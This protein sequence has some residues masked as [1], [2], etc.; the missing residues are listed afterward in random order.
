MTVDFISTGTGLTVKFQNL[1]KGLLDS[2]SYQWNFG[3]GSELSQ[4]RNPSHTYTE[5]GFFTVRLNV[6]DQDSTV[7][8]FRQYTVAVTDKA[9]THLP[10]SIYDLIDTYIPAKLF[11]CM[12]GRE[13]QL[14]IQKWQ[15]Y[16]YPLVCHCIPTG[17]YTNEL[18][19]E[20]LENQLVMQLA[21]RDFMLQQYQL[22]LGSEAAVIVENNSY[23]N[24]ELDACGCADDSGSSCTPGSG[25][26]D[27]DGG[28]SG[29]SSS[30]SSRSSGGGIKAIKTGPTEVEYFNES[31][32]ESSATRN[33]IRA[34]EKD[35]LL[36]RITQEACYLAQSLCIVLPFCGEATWLDPYVPEV[37]NKRRPGLLDGPDP[38]FP[39]TRSGGGVFYG[40]TKK[41]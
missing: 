40:T 6:I 18:Y 11:G 29:G 26:D 8:G 12:S 5:A 41:K 23:T 25:D 34:A 13:K 30:S 36:D 19:Y 14:L 17:E 33:I 3:D 37:V 22:M 27:D 35:N 32:A 24:E 16:I 20:A 38:I 9:C 4:E 10:G 31:E 15:L 28:G 7:K 1:S 2:Y 21:A 39:A